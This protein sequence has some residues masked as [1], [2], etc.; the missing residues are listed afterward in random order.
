MWE[1]FFSH[2]DGTSKA[3]IVRFHFNER[4]A[5]FDDLACLNFHLHNSIAKLPGGHDQR[6]R[7]WD[8]TAVEIQTHGVRFALGDANLAL[9]SVQG[10]LR[11]RGFDCVLL[12]NHLEFGL[13]YLDLKDYQ[14]CTFRMANDKDGL[15]DVRFDTCGIWAIGPLGS[16]GVDVTSSWAHALAGA[17]HP[18]YLD[19]KV[20]TRGYSATCRWVTKPPEFN[21]LGLPDDAFQVVSE[22]V[23]GYDARK[24]SNTEFE[25]VTFG[26]DVARRPLPAAK[27]AVV[28]ATATP[29]KKH[30][31]PTPRSRVFD[32][33]EW[34]LPKTADWP[35]LPLM[36]GLMAEGALWDPSGRLWCRSAHVPLLLQVGTDRKRTQHALDQNVIKLQKSQRWKAT[37]ETSWPWWV[38][39]GSEGSHWCATRDGPPRAD[40]YWWHYARMKWPS[41]EV[42]EWEQE[43]VDQNGPDLF[44]LS[45]LATR[46]ARDR[47]LQD[48]LDEGWQLDELH[49]LT[50]L[51]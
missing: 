2:K 24:I 3:Q 44:Q 16:L 33:L 20:N 6:R 9:F 37:D 19:G 13:D 10:E 30:H 41:E 7:V 8:E 46:P 49:N 31:Q 36:R 48:L 11:A 27:A 26:Q 14:S 38:A 51:A 21:V 43:W 25:A 45:L 12:E 40:G 22:I 15:P 28:P 47:A 42:R 29:W 39:H 1:G 5:G 35:V 23:A 34:H 50:S 4:I 18:V 17:C 32:G